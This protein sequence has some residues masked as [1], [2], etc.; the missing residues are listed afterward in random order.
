[1]CYLCQML[2]I[3]FDFFVCYYYQVGYFVDNNDDIWYFF[4]CEFFGFKDWIV[5]FVVKIGLN[6]VVEYFVF[7]QGIFDVVIII[8]DVVDIYF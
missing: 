3:G 4:W 6:C 1:M 7:G 5:G 8:V 2:N